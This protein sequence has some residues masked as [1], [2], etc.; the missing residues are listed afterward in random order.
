MR[1]YPFLKF[2]ENYDKFCILSNAYVLVK[3][4]YKNYVLHSYL[5]LAPLICFL[6]H[7]LF[8]IMCHY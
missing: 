3:C 1:F 4:S 7:V 6:F 2:F 8:Q 5:L